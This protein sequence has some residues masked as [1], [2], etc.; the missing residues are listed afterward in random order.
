M[1]EFLEQYGSMVVEA[2]SAGVIMTVMYLAMT[3]G[4]AALDRE[5]ISGACSKD[6]LPSYIEG[7]ARQCPELNVRKEIKVSP[8]EDFDVRELVVSAF[9]RKQYE[10]NIL[11]K[12]ECQS[13]ASIRDS[14]KSG[15]VNIA[16]YHN[17]KAE[18]GNCRIVII[19]KDSGR[20][21]QWTEAECRVIFVNDEQ[22][23]VQEKDK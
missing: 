2:I 10:I 15:C 17:L 14:L 22:D 23:K 21:G 3:T 16:Y 11:T 12:E 6:V 19:A 13:K 9:G 18:K 4:A 5:A 8:N 20:F 1:N 7:A